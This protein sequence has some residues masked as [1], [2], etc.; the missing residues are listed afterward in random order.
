[1]KWLDVLLVSMIE[2]LE[3]YLI[4]FCLGRKGWSLFCQDLLTQSAVHCGPRLWRWEQNTRLTGI[5]IAPSWLVLFKVLQS[6]DK[7]KQI[8]EQLY[9]R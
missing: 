1:M 9:Q 8:V 5:Q 4:C 6:F 3:L 2:K 7:L